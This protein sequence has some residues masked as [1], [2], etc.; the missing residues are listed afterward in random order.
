M[1]KQS[2]AST[3]APPKGG[4]RE[5]TRTRLIEAAAQLI[6]EKGYDRTTLE[7]V[8]ARAGMTRGAIYGNFKNRDDLFLA[9]VATRWKPIIPAFRPGAAL[10]EQMRI[11]GEA[12]AAAAPARQAMALGAVAFQFYALTHKEMRALLARKNAEIYRRGE[13]GLLKFI[14]AKELPMP[15]DLF[16]RVLHAL[17]DGLMFLRFL[18]PELITDEVIIAAFQALA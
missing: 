6:T 16:V 3:L 8:A 11:L 1:P 15:P 2:K 5:R 7:E 14:P 18:T 10:K 9:V 13:Q 17:T 4:K 12:V